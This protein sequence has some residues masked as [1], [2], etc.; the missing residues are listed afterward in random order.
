MDSGP[1]SKR[2][3]TYLENRQNKRNPSEINYWNFRI[4]PKTPL[5][6][7]V[8]SKFE[9]FEKQWGMGWPCKLKNIISQF[10]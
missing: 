1:Y 4:P 5:E 3:P 8:L 10:L 2:T 9:I 6:L 7:K